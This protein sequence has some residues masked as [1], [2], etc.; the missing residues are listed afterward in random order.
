MCACSWLKLLSVC[1]GDDI[2][3]LEESYNQAQRQ[4][5]DDMINAC[6]VSL[7]SGKFRSRS[8]CN[9]MALLLQDYEK[10][11]EERSD[12]IKE[13]LLIYVDICVGVDE[14]SAQ[15]CS[16]D[17]MVVILMYSLSLSQINHSH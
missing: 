13:R 6:Q 4:W 3:K 12:F 5:M 15:V 14:R 2:K 7:S 11:E 8:S 17:I 1:V 10:L 9:H 16:N